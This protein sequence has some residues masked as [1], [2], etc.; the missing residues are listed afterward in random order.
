MLDYDGIYLKKGIDLTKN[1]NSK[2]CMACNYCF[3]IMVSNS[4]IMFAY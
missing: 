4:K 3:L 2:E 1:N